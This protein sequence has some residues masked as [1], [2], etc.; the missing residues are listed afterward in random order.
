MRFTNG[1]TRDFFTSSLEFCIIRPQP[2]PHIIHELFNVSMS[3]GHFIDI[4]PIRAVP[5]N[6]LLGCTA[7][8]RRAH[9]WPHPLPSRRQSGAR[10]GLDGAE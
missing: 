9:G 7:T 10:P 5:S 3:G 6:W 8:S 2:M 1:N 4:G